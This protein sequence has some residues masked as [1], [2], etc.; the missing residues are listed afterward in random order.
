MKLIF[1]GPQGSG[2]GTQAKIISSKLGIDPISTGDLLRNV[3]G[4]LKER[5]DEYVNKGLLIP[6]DLM[7]DIL[8]QRLFND[9]ILD[10]FPR[11][12]KQAE[13]LDSIVNIDK[14]VEISISDEEAVKRLAGRRTCKKCGAIFNI[15][16]NPP[17]EDICDKCGG[18]LIKREDDNDEAIK[19]RLEVYHSETEKVLKRYDV[20]K[21]NGEQDIEKVTSD[22]LDGLGV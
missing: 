17:K 20:L 12:L 22:I 4:D 10:G 16:T 13:M 18:G 5:V 3:E 19:K 9:F 14:V 8:K 2:K 21:I 7:L 11:N 6:D 15:Y 1:I